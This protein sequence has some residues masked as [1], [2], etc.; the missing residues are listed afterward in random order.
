MRTVTYVALKDFPVMDPTFVIT[1]NPYNRINWPVP[2]PHMTSEMISCRKKPIVRYRI[3]ENNRVRRKHLELNFWDW[4]GFIKF[5][6]EKD[7]QIWDRNS[8]EWSRWILIFF[9]EEK[10]L[11]SNCEGDN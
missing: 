5:G 6:T 10:L 4:V 8:M 7:D 9:V 1:H 11:D 2:E 3:H